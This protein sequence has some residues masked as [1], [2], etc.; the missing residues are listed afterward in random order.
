MNSIVSD[1]TSPSCT[2]IAYFDSPHGDVAHRL[3]TPPSPIAVVEY[4][5]S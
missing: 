2:V 1:V 5:Q 4:K 3:D